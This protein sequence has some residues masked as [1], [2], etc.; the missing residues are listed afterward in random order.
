MPIGL[1]STFSTH[2][3]YY[4]FEA[5]PAMT[6]YFGH[7]SC[8]QRLPELKVMT[9]PGTTSFWQISISMPCCEPSLSL[10]TRVRACTWSDSQETARWLLNSCIAIS[11]CLKRSSWRYVRACACCK[12]EY[13]LVGEKFYRD[14]LT[15]G[16]SRITHQ[17]K[18]ALSIETQKMQLRKLQD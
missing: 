17:M 11:I 14:N 18:L 9:S 13:R 4:G 6:F 5:V 16:V 8:S 10:T 2:F 15:D 1:N 3:A 12:S 7:T